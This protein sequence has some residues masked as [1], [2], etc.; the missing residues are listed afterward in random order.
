M[1]NEKIFINFADICIHVSFLLFLTSEFIG[2]YFDNFS[3][4]PPMG[5]AIMDNKLKDEQE[6]T[7][8]IETMIMLINH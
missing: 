4:A 3:I 1:N 2:Q 6:E 8:F 5:Y 7:K